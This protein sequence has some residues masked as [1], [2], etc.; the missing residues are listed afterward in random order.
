MNLSYEN[1]HHYLNRDVKINGEKYTPIYYHTKD[2]VG[3]DLVIYVNLKD[4][5]HVLSVNLEIKHPEVLF[6]SL[7]ADNYL[8]T[9][10]QALKLDL[11][12]PHK[13]I[14]SDD[15]YN[16]LGLACMFS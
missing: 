2:E 12:K 5:M 14:W 13:I 7:F 11:E 6:S 10:Y 16:D 15:P 9:D 8:I 3:G 4:S 1:L